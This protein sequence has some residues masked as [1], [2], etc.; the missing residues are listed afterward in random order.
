MKL[1]IIIGVV[2]ILFVVFILASYIKAPT[3]RAL[4][5][6]GLRKNP[7]FVIGKSALRI[8][9]LQRVDKL[10]LKMIS[11]DVKTKESVPTNEYINVNIDS[12]VKIKVGSSKEMLE[13]AASNFLNKN[14]DYIRNSVGDVLEGNVREI[15][16][17]MRLEDIVQDRKMFAE[18]VQENAAPDMAR[19][20]LEIVSFNVQN[21]TDE[22]NVI[23]NLGIDRVVSISKSA[24]ISR[25]ES[26]RDIEVAKANATKQ[27]ND[28]RIEAETAIAERNNELEIKKQE[29]KRAADVKKAEA[30]A[31]YEIQQQEQ[32]KTIEITTADANIAKQEK[33]I[34]L[35]EKEIAVKEKTLDADIRKQAEAESI[36]AK[37]LADAESIKARGLAEAEAMEKKA[38]AMAKYGKAAM[39]EMIIKVLPQMAEAIAKPLESIDKVTIIDG[40][41]GENGVGTFSGNVPSVLAKTIESIKET[42]GFDLTEVM[43]ANTY[44]AKTTKNVNFTGLPEEMSA[45][46]K[47]PETDGKTE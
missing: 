25:A 8:P 9:F 21:V 24:Q 10:E 35:R 30:D 44:D 19:M 33:E 32:R 40:G 22:G 43:K 45:A 6:S 39:T 18:K 3:D 16:G 1:A 12:A 34:E 29:L 2:V 13:K 41:S 20:G 42:T 26:E 15:I 47:E 14:E 31:A 36:K 37:G 7:K 27:A 17:Q 5:V 4:I 11:V 28:A 38:E 46:A 23:E